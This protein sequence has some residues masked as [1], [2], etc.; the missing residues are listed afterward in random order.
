MNNVT[1]SSSTPLTARRTFDQNSEQTKIEL[2]LPFIAHQLSHWI[3]VWYI[4]C[5]YKIYLLA[6]GVKIGLSLL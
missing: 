1:S 2:I 5:V 3:N 6:I 4:V